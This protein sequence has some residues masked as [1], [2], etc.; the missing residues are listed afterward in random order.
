VI[1]ARNE[2][3]LS[4]NA[5]KRVAGLPLDTAVALTDTLAYVPVAIT[6]EEATERAL[7]NRQDL[8]AARELEEVADHLVTVERAEAFPTLDL[9]L[10][11]ARRASSNDFMP[12]DSEFSQSASAALALQI[13]LFDGRRAQGRVLQ[14]RADAV[15]ARERLHALDRDVRLQVLDAWQS[16]RAAAEGVEATRATVDRARRA[17]DIALVRFRNGLS[18][19]LE[20]D[21]SEQN[22]VVAQSNAAEALYLHMT[23]VA[24]LRHAMG[25][26]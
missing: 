19:Q 10:D 12:E 5:L 9:Q 25:E 14:A 13:P 22:L 4:R 26:R 18:T 2:L 23:A 1:A 20:L 8:L 11:V 24:R 7:R 21:E 17:Y 6:L 16:E 3:D 15:A